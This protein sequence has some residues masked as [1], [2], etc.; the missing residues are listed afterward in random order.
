M[1]NKTSIPIG[2]ILGSARAEADSVMLSRAFIETADYRAL[3]ETRD[4]NYVVGRRG[5]GKSALFTRLKE[6]FEQQEHIFVL[7]TKPEEHEVLEF[8]KLLSESSCTYSEMRAIARVTWKIHLLQS[9]VKRVLNHHKLTR[10]TEHSFLA[11]YAS[12]NKNVLDDETTGRC[13]ILIR[14]G[15]QEGGTSRE[16][17]GKIA[18]IF[19]LNQLQTVIQRTLSNINHSVLILYDG[20]DEGWLPNAAATAVLGGLSSAIADLDDAKTGIHCTLFI[21][22]NMFRALAHFDGDFSRHIE[23]HALRLQWDEDSLFHLIS[24]RLRVALDLMSIESDVK[25]WNRFVDTGLQN[26][27]GFELCLRNTLYRPRDILVL[28]NRAYMVATRQGRERIIEQDIDSAATSI[29]HDRL[30]DLLKEYDSVL[31]GLRSFVKLFENRPAF[32]Q[33]AAVITRLEDH[34]QSGQYDTAESSD[35]ALLGS[36]KQV[37]LALY[38]VGFIGVEDKSRGG[39]VFCHDGSRSE[40]E[41]LSTDLKT[42]IHPCYWKAL[43]LQADTSSQSVVVQ[44]NDEYE[45]KTSP[46]IKDLRTKRLGQIVEE[47]PKVPKGDEGSTEF[48][49]WVFRAVK[50]LFSGRLSNPELKPNAAAIQRRDIVATN[51][52]PDG[53]WRRIREDYETRQVIFEVKN[54]EMLKP[55]DFR[56]ALSYMTGDY[57][58]FVVLIT[59]S[60]NE[61]VSDTERGWISEIWHTQKGLTFILPASI[62]VRGL[63][64]LRNAKRYDYIEDVLN[65]RLD[66]FVRSYVSLKHETRRKGKKH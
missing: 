5:T 60:Q 49:D 56:Q 51:M 11:T 45:T 23:G 17:P 39:F 25:V 61:G 15:L 54:Y 30:E 58:K 43:E 19:Q 4:F 13:S 37:F 57:G 31:P 52:A 34:I 62:L 66:T 40:I 3:I 7:T 35:F 63:S 33:L 9:V 65:K 29:S 1:P 46:E 36:G 6:Y 21:R 24:S 20:L 42:V 28:L 47:L 48:E 41:A 12:N 14:F 55:E 53:F 18:G 8:Q 26:R 44:I 38:G 16:L 64:K 22:D 10:T 27:S 2:N 50:I 59:R 32:D